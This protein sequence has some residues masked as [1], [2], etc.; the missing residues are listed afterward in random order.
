[1]CGCLSLCCTAELRKD[2]IGLATFMQ[3]VSITVSYFTL[4]HFVLLLEN[5]PMVL[6]QCQHYQIAM[7]AGEQLLV[8]LVRAFYD[9]PIPGT[10]YNTWSPSELVVQTTIHKVD[11]PLEGL[12]NIPIGS[13]LP[14]CRHYIMDAALNPLPAGLVEE[15]C[16]GGAQVGMGYLNRPDANAESFIE[17]PFCSHVDRTRGWSMLFRTGDRRRFLPRGMLEFHGWVAGDKQTK[18]QGF[19]IDLGEVEQALYQCLMTQTGQGIVDIA[20]IARSVGEETDSASLIDNRQLIAF[21]VSK[22][23]L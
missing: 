20:I 1:M 14:N 4:T 7:F 9:I 21:T 19:R 5:N 23:P 8:R 16:V 2:P 3:Q 6:H 13:P 15:I 17:D 10:V 12:V 18:L 11:G 22:I